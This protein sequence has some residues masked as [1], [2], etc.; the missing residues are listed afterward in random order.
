VDEKQEILNNYNFLI[1]N[2]NKLR[3]LSIYLKWIID[4]V[5]DYDIDNEDFIYVY[6]K[7]E[8]MSLLYGIQNDFIHR[9]KNEI[10]KMINNMDIKSELNLSKY[11][12]TIKEELIKIHKDKS[13]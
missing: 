11:A 12:D 4:N 8:E 7:V 6:R 3:Y 9:F 10:N 5:I 13:V 2:I 1:Y